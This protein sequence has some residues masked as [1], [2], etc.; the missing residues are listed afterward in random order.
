MPS[1]SQNSDAMTVRADGTAFVFFGAKQLA[2]VHGFDCCLDS[3]V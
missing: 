3:G 1:A 2:S